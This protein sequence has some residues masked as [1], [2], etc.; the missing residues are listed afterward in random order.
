MQRK[1][2]LAIGGDVCL[3]GKLSG[4]QGAGNLAAVSLELQSL[5][6]K[7]GCQLVWEEDKAPDCPPG[8]QT[9]TREGRGFRAK[10]EWVCRMISRRRR[11]RNRPGSGSEAKTWGFPVSRNHCPHLTATVE[12]ERDRGCPCLSLLWQTTLSQ[13]RRESPCILTV[14]D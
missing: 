4:T 13:L 14:S 10:V 12:S 7:M 3:R 9:S 11:Q 2:G 1:R 8:N 5:L 6:P